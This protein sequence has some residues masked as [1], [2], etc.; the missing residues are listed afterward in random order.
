MS[1]DGFYHP[2]FGAD[3]VFY[4]FCRQNR[5]NM[6]QKEAI[7]EALNR[8]GGKAKMSEICKWAIAIGDFSGSKNPKNTIRNCIY[9]NPKDFRSSGNGC[10]ELVSYQEEIANR[11]KEIARLKAE[12]ERLKTIKTEDEFVKRLLKSTKSL[13]SVNRKHADYVRLVLL[14][15]GRDEEEKELLAWIERRE[16]KVVKKKTNKII[17]K[18]SNSQIFNGPITE[19]EF[20]GGG[21]NNE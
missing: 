4:Y 6:K 14:K 15:L 16:Q 19:S 3:G 2:P 9:T 13:F 10:W 11:D 12:V 21:T 7:I 18:I 20:G 17:Q 5:R 8:L 1:V